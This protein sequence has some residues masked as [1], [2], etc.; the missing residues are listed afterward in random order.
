MKK[1]ILITIAALLTMNVWG[2]TNTFPVTGNVGIGTTAP[3]QKLQVFHSTGQGDATNGIHVTRYTNTTSNSTNYNKAIYAGI[4]NYSISPGVTDSG[5]RIGVD[6][7]SYAGTEGFQGTLSKAY[8][9]WARSGIHLAGTGAHINNVYGIFAEIL[10]AD[11]D[12][13]MDNAYGIFINNSAT[14]G[15]I[16]NRFDL[17]ASS[18]NAKNYFAGNVGIGTTDPTFKLDVSNSARIQNNVLINTNGGHSSGVLFQESDVTKW[19]LRLTNSDDDIGL[20]DG[21]GYKLFIDRTSGNVGIGT[22]NPTANLHV[23][24]KIRTTHLDIP[25]KVLKSD[26]TNNVNAVIGWSESGILGIAGSLFIAPRTNLINAGIGFWTANQG[27]LSAEPINRMYIHANG[28][29]GIGTTNPTYKLSVKG[30]IGCGE[31]KVE[32]V[33][34]WSDF[35]FEPEYNLMSLKD[36]ETYIKTN[37][38]L[39]EIPTTAQVEENGIAIGEMNAKLLQKI[40][41]LTLYI[42]Q[43]E[44]RVGKLENK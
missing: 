9:V 21:T 44:N 14:T 6:A 43:L 10:N 31:V 40:E 2:Q 32:D 12:G 27:N 35:V 29:V 25:E 18:S 7:S 3:S 42:I 11:A 38:H 19:T 30:T 5:Y 26:A 39:P 36:L 41:E 1:I 4:L 33:T 8:G 34:S 37:K 28:N 16:T 13:L 17:Y 24:G 23:I 22:T 15:T 20:Y